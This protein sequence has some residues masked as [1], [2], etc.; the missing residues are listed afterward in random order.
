MASLGAS[1]F[2]YIKQMT[3]TK[4]DSNKRCINRGTRQKVSDIRQEDV[5]KVFYSTL[6][7]LITQ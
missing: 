3:V 6:P 5:H 7:L 4:N 2:C 1:V